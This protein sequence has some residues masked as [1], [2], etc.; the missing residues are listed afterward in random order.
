MQAM[1]THCAYP[2]MLRVFRLCAEAV[3]ASLYDAGMALSIVGGSIGCALMHRATT[4]LGASRADACLVGILVGCT[5]AVMFFS[6]VVELHGP[7]FGFVG[8]SMLAFAHWLREPTAGAGALTGCATAAAYFAHATGAVLPGVLLLFALAWPAFLG[9]IDRK[10]IVATSSLLVGVH[11]S[12]LIGLSAALRALGLAVDPGHAGSYLLEYAQRNAKDFHRL[13]TTFRVEWL[14][15]Y[16]PLSILWL[17]GLRSP[18]TRK[19]VGAFAICLTGYLLFTFFLLGDYP[20]YGA[21]LLPLAWPAALLTVSSLPRWLVCSAVIVGLST[22]L[23]MIA[24]YDVPERG[25]EYAAGFRHLFEEQKCL[26]LVGDYVDLEARFVQMPDQPYLFILDVATLK[27]DAVEKALPQVDAHLRR[28]MR[29]YERLILTAGAEQ[30]MSASSIVTQ[31]RTGGSVLLE[32]LRSQYRLEPVAHRGFS[33][34]VLR[35]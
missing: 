12:L 28:E 34:Y 16:L 15:P 25:E 3:G 11:A 13:G 35:E 20:E 22:G 23:H 24:Q 30:L 6:T 14:V 4:V 5:P 27:P 26:L 2:I 18:C 29:R 31:A 17:L 21:Y 33:G 19:M 10:R 9:R 8:L 7:F 1:P 32:F